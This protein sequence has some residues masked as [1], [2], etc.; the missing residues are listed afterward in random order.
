MLAYTVER[1]PSSDYGQLLYGSFYRRSSAFIG[2]Q[3]RVLMFRWAE[4]KHIWPPMN[5]DERR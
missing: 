3:Y 2:G 1:T 5:A 4:E